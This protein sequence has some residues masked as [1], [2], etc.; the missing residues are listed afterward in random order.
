MK[1]PTELSRPG[2]SPTVPMPRL[3]ETPAPAS[4]EVDETSSEGAT[5]LSCRMSL[6][7]VYS[8]VWAVTALTAMGTSDKA[9]LRRVAVMTMSLVST[10]C[11]DVA[12]FETA[13]GCFATP[14][15]GG[16]VVGLPDSVL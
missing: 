11:G 1:M 10:G 3:R 2:L 4:D 13:G 14:W 9:S 7:P 5:W 15:V 8:R 12:C 6:A 16:A